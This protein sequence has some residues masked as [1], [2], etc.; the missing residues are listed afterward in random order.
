[1][2]VQASLAHA[3]TPTDVSD[4]ARANAR[5]AASDLERQAKTSSDETLY[6]QCGQAYFDLYNQ[7]PTDPT[8]DEL[9]FNAALCFQRAGSSGA[10]I[11]TFDLLIRHFPASIFAPRGLARV[12]QMY[13]MIGSY[14]K[15]AE[16]LETYAT[17]YAGEN[18]AASALSE[19]AL[20]RGA[21]GE[22]DK[23]IAD[24]QQLLKMFGARKHAEAMQASFGL[25]EVY[26]KR[27]AADREK[28][29]R[30]FL[31]QFGS[32]DPELGI[33][34]HALLG[35]AVWQRA[36]AAKT[37]DGSCITMQRDRTLPMAPR[38][39]KPTAS[40]KRCGPA[41]ET[42]IV[43]VPRNA[44]LVDEA[45]KSFAEASKLYEQTRPT[46]P[47]ARHAYARA[48]LLIAERDLEAFLAVKFP[49]NLNFSPD[50]PQQA[51]ASSQKF[52][53][54]IAARQK[55]GG[56][57]TV[58]L[59]AVLMIK[60]AVNSIA[61]A[62]R[63][64]F[65]AHA[66][67]SELMT[68]E[69]PRDVRTG[70]YAADKVE[71]FCDK[72]TEVAEPLLQRAVQG[73]DICLTKA[74][75]LGI[76]DAVVKACARERAAIGPTTFA[77]ST[78]LVA[79]SP[80]PLPTFEEEPVRRNRKLP[81][82]FAEATDK[83]WAVFGPQ[84]IPEPQCGPLARKFE[85]FAKQAASADAYYMAGMTY[86]RCNQLA[87]AK[88]SYGA[89][90]ALDPKH[91]KSI[92]NLG[93]LEYRA[94][95]L[96]GARKQW[97]QALAVNLKL[98]SAH[99]GMATLAIHDLRKLP[100]DAPA[101]KQLT[102]TA[103]L[104]ASSAAAVGNRG[105]PGPYVQLGILA[106][107]QN[108]LPLAR[109]YADDAKKVDTAP[110]VDLLLAAIELRHG[111]PALHILEAAAAAPWKLDDTYLALG[112]H[113][114]ALRRYHDATT[115]LAKVKRTSYDV[116]IARGVAAR[117]M[118][119]LADAEAR[120]NEALA[121]DPSRPEALFDLGV[122]WKDYTAARATDPVS[123]KAAFRKA[124]DAFRRVNTPE[125]KLLADDCDRAI[126]VL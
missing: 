83:F 52:D 104:H 74:G 62:Q 13:A 115:A 96:A 37:I 15:A 120:Y 123:A 9:L 77:L 57:A 97:E 42:T 92:S 93:E 26:G 17:K 87:K 49:T 101:R 114:L 3:D 73:Y 20:Y 105:G 35:E 25:I 109:A 108:K 71:A 44:R 124:A 30:D 18:D 82:P 88:A 59:E 46:S 31:R 72:M 95:N 43:A 34:A 21:L 107:E 80:L 55:L 116:V 100:A 79:D 41:S 85:A 36:C 39:T 8:G 45:M 2:L 81:A 110:E 4:V 7:K 29:L 11:S 27:S 58:K 119:K 40:S 111:R 50:R 84:G 54:F 47:V 94:G 16:K 91:G 60:D 78:E 23:Q 75:E 117:G 102:A 66:F 14:A 86:G 69:I 112:L 126:A 33:R 106:L 68:A 61:A 122:L 6:A 64:G 53:D 70:Q 24:T 51:K 48:K 125:A 63:I 98:F 118:G 22:Y 32:K 76:H 56:A 38:K 1:M 10:A 90:L 121:L 28:H 113:Y 103:E 19:A 12:G 99:L 89:A 65:L 67:A 5:K